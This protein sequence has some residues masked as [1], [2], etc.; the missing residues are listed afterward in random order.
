MTGSFD[1]GIF[2]V[3]GKPLE[4][5]SMEDAEAAIWQELQQLINTPVP[6]DELTKVKNKT[7]STMV[8][9]EMALLDKAMNLAYFELLGDADLLNHETDKY[10]AVTAEQIQQQ[11]KSLFRKDNSSTMIYLADKQASLTGTNGEEGAEVYA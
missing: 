11:A 3:E 8:F 4:T 5:V 6:A 2:V 9:A 10:L 7:E 1:K